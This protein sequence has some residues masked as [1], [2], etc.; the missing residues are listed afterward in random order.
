MKKIRM[1]LFLI[2]LL[3]LIKGTLAVSHYYDLNLVYDKGN[4]SYEYVSVKILEEG[5]VINNL[6]GKYTAELVSFDGNILNTT[7]FRIPLTILYDNF[8]ENGTIAEGGERTLDKTTQIV[9][10]P[11]FDNTKEINIYDNNMIKKLTIDVSYYAKDM[12]KTKKEKVQETS[13]IA[14]Y[15]E[16]Q[17]KEKISNKIIVLAAAVIIAMI[18]IAVIIKHRNKK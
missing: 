4:I 2:I 5:M 6:P 1:I 13:E 18:I 15:S 12:T 14:K 9:V 11:Y 17:K 10:L 8:D 16:E 3:I 7:K